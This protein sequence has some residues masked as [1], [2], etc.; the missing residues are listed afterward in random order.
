MYGKLCGMKTTVEI[1]DSLFLEAKRYAAEQR[2]P[3]R[4]VVEFGLRRV[5]SE[6]S[7]K[8]KPFK[9]KDGSFKGKGMVKD[10]TWPEIRAMIYEGR[11][12]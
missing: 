7:G 6:K 4:E 11:G 12:G 2:I 5:L 1:P 9:L 8:S 10:Y 3:F